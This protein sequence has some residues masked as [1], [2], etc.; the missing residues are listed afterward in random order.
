MNRKEYILRTLICAGLPA[1]GVLLWHVLND[2]LQ[3]IPTLLYIVGAPIVL[4]AFVVLILANLSNTISR[5]HDLDKS[6]WWC[7][8][9][10]LLWLKYVLILI[11]CLVP[12]T[13]KPNK[14]GDPA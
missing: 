9:G 12:G 6:G 3:P 7:L 11:L 8:I 1:I 4:V 14:F 13:A 2:V 5:L 10:L